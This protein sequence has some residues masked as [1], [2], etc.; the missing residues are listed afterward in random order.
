[1]RVQES[2]AEMG[3]ARVELVYGQLQ[4]MADEVSCEL[5]QRGMEVENG[6]AAKTVVPQAYK[7]L[8]WGTT[9]ECMKYLARRAQENKDAVERTREG[10]DLMAKEA[11]RRV[12]SVFGW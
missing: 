5:V 3:E 8:V 2:Q 1:M 7:Y 9:G 4:G 6:E 10:R 11:F 12:R